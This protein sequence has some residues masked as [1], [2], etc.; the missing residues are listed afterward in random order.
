MYIS[1]PIQETVPAH[2]ATSPIPTESHMFWVG[3]D[4]GT[5]QGL[6]NDLLDLEEPPEPPVPSTGT[7]KKK[8][9]RRKKHKMD[10]RRE[11]MT[12]PAS[13]GASAS[14]D[15]IFEMDLSTDDEATPNTRWLAS[16]L[17]VFI[18]V[19]VNVTEIRERI[20]SGVFVVNRDPVTVTF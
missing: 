7:A 10:P 6:D 18:N 17:T 20:N 3:S 1:Y 2:L 9:R 5:A 19:P 11:E 15:D 16:S 14:T 13:V 4:R 8:K 12:P